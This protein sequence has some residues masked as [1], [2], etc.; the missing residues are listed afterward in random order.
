MINDKIFQT[1]P[2]LYHRH[3]RKCHVKGGL[4]VTSLWLEQSQ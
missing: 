4:E 3:T 2:F 1:L